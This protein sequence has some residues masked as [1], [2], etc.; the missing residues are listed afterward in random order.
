MAELWEAEEGMKKAI[1][2]LPAFDSAK[3]VNVVID[4]IESALSARD[5]PEKR[6][7]FRSWRDEAGANHTAQ[8]Q[9]L[10]RNK[11]SST[12][13]GIP[14]SHRSIHP[15]FPSCALLAIRIFIKNG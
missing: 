5:G 3:S 9:P 13:I 10:R 4:V 11:M 8:V 1:R 7:H 14:S 2:K 15:T 6:G 12:G